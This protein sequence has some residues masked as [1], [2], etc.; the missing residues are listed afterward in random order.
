MTRDIEVLRTWFFVVFVIAV[1]G[2]NAVPIIYSF[3]P[4]R[5][6]LI[7]RL[8]MVQAVAFAA[9]ID[10]SLMVRF[11]R[12]SSVLALFWIQTLVFTGIAGATFTLAW[13]IWS[14][15]HPRKKG[16][17]KL[18]LN[19]N[20]YDF[21]KSVVQIGLPALATLYF[22]V[23]QLWGLPNVQ[24]VMGTITAVATFLG[25]ILAISTKTY[26]SSEAKYDGHLV[27]EQGEESSTLRLKDVDPK[28]LDEKREILLKVDDY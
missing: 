19:S 4:W 3:S 1:I 7:G 2:T 28:A 17:R 9:A 15:N 25:V 20:V 27:I 14:L 16:K 24:Q 26:N 6:R 12:P 22:T 11:L 13:G 8:F 10:I 18:L 5:S 23:A 21:L